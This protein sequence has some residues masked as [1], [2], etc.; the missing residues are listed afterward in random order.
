[1]V[2]FETSIFTR[3]IDSLLSQEEYRVLQ[4][5]LIDTPTLGNIITGSGGLRKVRWKGK[6]HGKRG[7]TRIIYYWAKNSEQIF[8]LYVYAKNEMENIT[9]KQ[10]EVLKQAVTA[11]FKNER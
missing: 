2:I 8:M 1:M 11:E 9:K 3:K 5:M 10:L 6:G 7:G 4:N